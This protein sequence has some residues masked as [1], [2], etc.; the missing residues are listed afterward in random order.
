MTSSMTYPD[1][2]HLGLD[3]HK[4]SI[5]VGLLEPTA[6]TATVDKIFNDEPSVRRLI[7]QFDDPSK[8]RVCYEA[9]P[10]GYELNRLLAGMGVSCQVIAPSLIPRA[11]GDRVKT[12]KRDCRR[13]ARLH[14]AGELVAIRVPTPAEEAVRDLCRA[15]VDLVDDRNRARKRLGAFLL[16]HARV[17]RAGSAWTGKHRVWLGAQ[18]FDERAMDVTYQHY[19]ATLD[20]RDAAVDAIQADLKVWYDREPFADAVRRL[21][22]YRG[23]AHLGALT[24]ASEVCDWRRF[25]RATAF[26]GFVG[27]VPSEYSSGGST[28]RGHLTKAGNAHLR[29]QLVESAWAYQHRPGVGAVLRDRQEGVDPAT[30]ARAWKAQLRLCGRFRRLAVVKHHKGVVVAAVARELAG[31]A[32]GEMTAETAA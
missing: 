30:L 20:A 3:V 6:Q 18:R 32:W 8:L 10:T 25:G 28:H 12:D 5:S 21:G 27:L 31:F 2:I 16:R 7:G 26:M 23:I 11:P 19:L 24:L 29:T 17:Y 14:R 4:D 22:A 1:A 13:L 15:R 9:G